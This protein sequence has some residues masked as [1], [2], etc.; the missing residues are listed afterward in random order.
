MFGGKRRD[1]KRV[2]ERKW[3]Q[4][5]VY[6]NS[7]V[8]FHFFKPNMAQVL[9][10]S[11]PVEG[12]SPKPG[13]NFVIWNCGQKQGNSKL[14]DI[15]WK[16]LEISTV[17]WFPRVKLVSTYWYRKNIV[18]FWNKTSI[19][20]YMKRYSFGL[21]QWQFQSLMKNW[22]RE[23]LI[24]SMESHQGCVEVNEDGG[25]KGNWSARLPGSSNAAGYSAPVR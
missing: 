19:S 20:L 11:L 6:F 1:E 5:R 23:V 24:R 25:S 10:I 13:S 3:E 16:P 7:I 8:W 9:I 17:G 15:L 14:L 18:L 22:G 2:G 4:K 21:G 12:S